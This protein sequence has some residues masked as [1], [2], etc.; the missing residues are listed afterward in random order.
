MLAI[1]LDFLP[2]TYLTGAPNPLTFVHCAER[3]AESL[4]LLEECE[5]KGVGGETRSCYGYSGDLK[6]NP[7]NL[8]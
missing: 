7:N 4:T 8:G 6:H 3:V 1:T 5:V 2:S